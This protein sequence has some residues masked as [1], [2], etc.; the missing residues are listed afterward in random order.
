MTLVTYNLRYLYTNPWFNLSCDTKGYNLDMLLDGLRQ[1]VNNHRDERE[2]CVSMIN[3]P[4]MMFDA[5]FELLERFVIETRK[6]Y[7]DKI[8]F[9][10]YPSLLDGR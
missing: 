10:T 9:V 7:G 3:H 4:K 8:S 1:Y 5:Q 6:E 2:I